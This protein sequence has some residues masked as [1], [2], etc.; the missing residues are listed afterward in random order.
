VKEAQRDVQ[1]FH[2]A[3]GCG[4]GDRAAPGF[5]NVELR[6]RL[7]EEE[8]EELRDACT[9]LAFEGTDRKSAD[10][11]AAVDA[12]ADIAYVVIGTAVEW[13]VDL[14]A[15]WDEVQ[16]ANMAKVGGAKREDG[17]VTK[18]PGWQPPDIAGVLRRQVERATREGIR[19]SLRCEETDFGN[20]CTEVTGHDGEC[21]WEDLE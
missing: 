3:M 20:R 8:V 7:I 17:K 10:F 6:L 1:A 21:R 5:S 12:L 19:E 16:R 18:P 9:S 14:A 4:I 13:G 2:E 15:V 11:P